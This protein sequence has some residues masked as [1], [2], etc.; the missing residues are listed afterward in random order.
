VGWSDLFNVGNVLSL[1]S[2]A[3]A[4]MLGL[5]GLM[6]IW[7]TIGAIWWLRR[8]GSAYRRELTKYPLKNLDG[9]KIREIVTACQGER[10]TPWGVLEYTLYGR[11]HFC[12]FM[13]RRVY[14]LPTLA[15][16]AFTGYLLFFSVNGSSRNAVAWLSV[17][18]VYQL[19][20]ILSAFEGICAY[21]I[22]GSFRRFYHVGMRLNEKEVPD[23]DDAMYEMSLLFPMIASAVVVNVLTFICAYVGWCSFETK[24]PLVATDVPALLLQGLYFVTSTM[25]TVG[26]GDIVPKNSLGQII[27]VLMHAQSLLLVVG[28]FSALM[29]FGLKSMNGNDGH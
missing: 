25:A 7:T 14:R 24:I 12:R 29:S 3:L 20:V 9:G 1:C 8:F 6:R 15:L 16:A 18:V 21:I 5:V 23:A 11:S 22:V 28:M 4:A 10:V 26:Y 27:A 19:G 2:F 13:G 17:A